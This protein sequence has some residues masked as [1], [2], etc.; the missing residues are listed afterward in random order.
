MRFTNSGS[1]PWKA[2]EKNESVIWHEFFIRFG[3]N[4]NYIAQSDFESNGSLIALS[5]DPAGHAG[6][7]I[8]VDTVLIQTIYDYNENFSAGDII[9]SIILTNGWTFNVDDF[10]EFESIQGYLVK[11][12][13]GVRDEYF[14]VKLNE[15]PTADSEF[16]VLLTY[17]LNNGEEF[18]HTTET[19]KLK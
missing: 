4:T 2:L 6:D 16:S 10:N 19:V 15:A 17:K 14:E 3:F 12:I 9:N 11:N 5:C 18:T 13:E 7:K 1:N 8:G